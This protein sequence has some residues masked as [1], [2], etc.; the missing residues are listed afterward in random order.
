MSETIFRFI[1]TLAS[2]LIALSEKIHEYQEKK[3]TKEQ[4]ATALQKEIKDYEILFEDLM[5]LGKK[6]SSIIEQVKEQP[7]PHQA[8]EILDSLS[9][10]PKVVARFI[11]LFIELA[12]A[13]KEISSQRAFMDSLKESSHFLYDFVERM[14]EAYIEKNTVRIDGRFFRFFSTYRKEMLKGS[15]FKKAKISKIDKKDLQ[16]LEE[17]ANAVVRYLNEPFLRRHVRHPSIKKW[18]SSI[19][20]LYRAA[21]SIAF[22]PPSKPSLNEFVPSDLQTLA[23]FLEEYS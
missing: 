6:F 23:K 22:E 21:K 4:L 18:K 3:E 14:A 2:P 20:Y 9:Q 19:Q 13:C 7:T 17:K 8:M 5:E 16:S 12:K 1:T 11:M 10:T 15:M